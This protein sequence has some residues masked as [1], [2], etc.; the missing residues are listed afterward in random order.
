MWS[1]CRQQP[2]TGAVLQVNPTA[3]VLQWVRCVCRGEYTN[4]S[5][6]GNGSNGHSEVPHAQAE[7]KAAKEKQQQDDSNPDVASQG[8]AKALHGAAQEGL[9]D[10][11][12]LAFFPADKTG[13]I[14][15]VSAF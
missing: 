1:S 9:N 5:E 8:D 6:V 14:A 12:S 11:P 15:K 2:I 3:N 4:L 10:Q 7:D 13:Y